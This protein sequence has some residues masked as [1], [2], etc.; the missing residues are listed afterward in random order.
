M[1]TGGRAL[2]LW[3]GGLLIAALAAHYGAK[4]LHGHDFAAYHAASRALLSGEGIY[5]VASAEGRPYSYPP[6]L[7]VLLIPL[8]LLPESAAA[9]LWVLLS[10]AFLLGALH[11]C[12]RLVGGTLARADRR[13]AMLALLAVA[14][15]I[16]S[17][18]AN[19]Q[20]NLLV[21]LC[22]A[23]FAWL[24]MGERKSLSGA[25]LGL[26]TALKATPA[27]LLVYLLLKRDWRALGAA[28]ASL[29]FFLVALPAI[30]LGLHGALETNRIWV[31]RY[32]LPNLG[33]E[34]DAEEGPSGGGEAAQNGAEPARSVPR[35][36]VAG[37][38]LRAVVHRTFTWTVASTHSREPVFANLVRWSP[39]TAEWIYRALALL[40]VFGVAVTCRHAAPHSS[41]RSRWSLEL[42]LFLTTMLLVSPISRKAHFV[43]LLLPFAFV[44]ARILREGDRRP[45]LWCIPAAA[46]LN[47]TAPGII[48]RPA[49]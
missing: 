23:L 16:D 8:A 26:A 48:G 13:V 31:E 39:A 30:P 18:L 37:H 9:V 22:I 33:V 7:A 6:A 5:E 20:V 17:E 25:A 3:V 11:L 36:H 28:I 41:S 14:R 24:R 47:L 43:I 12:A 27:L 29:A 15:P 40:V 45:L 4:A 2:I 34:G 21:L 1:R 19:G 44:A 46:L 35:P 10:L 49:S 38:S 42:S 32:A